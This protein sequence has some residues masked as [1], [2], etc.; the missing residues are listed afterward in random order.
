MS[1]LSTIH[2]SALPDDAGVLARLRVVLAKCSWVG[3]PPNSS[4]SIRK[5]PKPRKP[6]KGCEIASSSFRP[7]VLARDRLHHWTAPISDSFHLELVKEFT[8][9]DI[10]QL[11][12]VL[13]TSIEPKTRENYSAGLLR[14]HQ[15]CDSQNIPESCRMPASDTLLA[16][17]VASWASKIATTTVGNW[18]SG[19]HFWH[20]LH[21]APW[22]G[23]A[24]LCMS[25]AGVNKLVPESSK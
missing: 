5:T 19:L 21:G 23:H 9:D 4:R 2:T 14:F 6:E 8:I 13:L 7:H 3:V 17:F 16:L 10:V 25:T 18:L 22:N 11:F 24:L 20:N 15:F 12:N 1:S